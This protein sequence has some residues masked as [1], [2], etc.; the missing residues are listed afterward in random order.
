MTLSE[1][2]RKIAI[3]AIGGML[4]CSIP[5]PSVNARSNQET[6]VLFTDREGKKT[7]G[8]LLNP[9]FKLIDGSVSKTFRFEDSLSIQIGATASA[10][11]TERISSGISAILGKERDA[12]DKAVEELTDIGLPVLTPLI[13]NFKDTDLKEPC[14]LYKLFSRI[15]PGY[16]DRLDRKA[17]LIRL[18][19]GE[20]LRGKLDLQE[21]QLRDQNGKITKIAVDSLRKIAVRRASAEKTFVVDCLRNSTQTE[22]LDSGISLSA[23]SRVEMTATGF[24]RLS[25][26]ED[27][28]TSGPDGKSEAGP[29]HSDLLTGGFPYG[30]LVG[31]VGAGGARWFAGSRLSKSGLG[32]GRLSF[33]IN[34]NEHWQ[35]N[36]GSYKLKVKATFCYDNGDP[37]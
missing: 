6:Y 23:N 31:R 37:Q 33:G 27:G 35:N 9:K 3:A 26:D 29:R 14:P 18:A 22:F 20:T 5:L 2:K 8:Y 4:L 17:D 15:I 12:R 25:F 1:A 21:L 19:N 32:A 34:D 24:A 16:A 28:W 36:V 10:S 7:E 13:Q 30:A 11:E